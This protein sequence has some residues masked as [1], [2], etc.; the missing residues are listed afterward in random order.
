MSSLARVNAG[1]WAMPSMSFGEEFVPMFQLQQLQMG[2][3]GPNFGLQ[4]MS[5]FTPGFGQN[6]NTASG[7]FGM[8]QMNQN[9]GMPNMN[10]NMGGGMPQMQQM[11]QPMGGNMNMG[12]T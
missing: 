7:Q 1:D 2:N 5:Q 9:N 3:M 4:Q 10:N 12:L 8:Q 11:N 6:T